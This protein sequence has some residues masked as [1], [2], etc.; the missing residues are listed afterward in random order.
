MNEETRLREFCGRLGADPAQ[1]ATMAAQLMKRATQLAAE[2]GLTREAAMA[3]LLQKALRGWEIVEQ[4]DK[5][6]G[7]MDSM[8]LEFETDQRVAAVEGVVLMGKPRLMQ[9]D[10]IFCEAALAGPMIVMKNRDV[11]GVIGHVGTVLGKNSI[12]IANFSLG[13]R[14]APT[15]PG[16]PLEAIAIVSTDELVGESVLAQLRATGETAWAIGGIIAGDRSVR[17]V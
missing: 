9:I 8:R 16:E 14:E 10:G 7:P 5:Y 17:I 1:S 15:K 4:H 3:H 13:R 12:N 11:P 2:R 6:S